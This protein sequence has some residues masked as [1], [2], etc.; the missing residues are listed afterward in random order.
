MT[1]SDI[2]VVQLRLS[3]QEWR[4]VA[5]MARLRRQSIEDLLREGLRLTSEGH[6]ESS[7]EHAHL[8]LVAPGVE[9]RPRGAR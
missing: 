9:A 3:R 5:E 2:Y 8:R 4:L 1:D 7:V 6:D